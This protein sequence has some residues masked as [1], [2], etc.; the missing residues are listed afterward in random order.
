MSTQQIINQDSDLTPQILLTEMQACRDRIEHLFQ[1][2]EMSKEA[3]RKLYDNAN[4]I[5]DK[6]CL[7]LSPAQ[8]AEIYGSDP[9]M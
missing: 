2:G 1:D 4:Y 5:I 8:L 6:Y 7:R 9:L 3:F